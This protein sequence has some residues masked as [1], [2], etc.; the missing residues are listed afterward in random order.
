M[1]ADKEKTINPQTWIA[2]DLICE[3]LRH[4]RI[5]IMGVRSEF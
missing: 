1:G 5:K 3:N 4:L 2:K